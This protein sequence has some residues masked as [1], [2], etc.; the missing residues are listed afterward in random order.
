MWIGRKP[1][2]QQLKEIRSM[3]KTRDQL[4]EQCNKVN[5]SGLKGCLQVSE[6]F[7]RACLMNPNRVK[8]IEIAPANYDDISKIVKG[9]N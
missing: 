4:L 9:G 7:C 2:D 3:K 5:A 8:P 6:A 1:I